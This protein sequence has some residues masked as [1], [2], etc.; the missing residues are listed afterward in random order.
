MRSESYVELGEKE[1]KLFECRPVVNRYD[2]LNEFFDAIGLCCED[3]ILTNRFLL[4]GDRT[5]ISGAQIL[6][7]ELYGAGEPTDEMLSGIVSDIKRPYKRVIGI[8]GGTVLDLSKLLCLELNG[9]DNVEKVGLTMSKGLPIVKACPV[10]LVPTT[11][12]TGS[13]VTNVAVLLIKSANTKLGLADTALYADEAALIPEMLRTLPYKPM[14]LSAIDA[15]IHA[16]ESYLS[17]K[18]NRI[19][20]ALSEEA[21][22]LLIKALASIGQPQL[23][24]MLTASNIAGIAFGNAG[25][26]MVHAMSYPIGGT[27]HLPHGEANY[28]VFLPVLR[29]YETLEGN[30]SFERLKD[31]FSEV[32]E[33]DRPLDALEALLER[34]YHRRGLKEIGADEDMLTAFSHDVFKRQQ[35]LLAN[36]MRP[37]TQE[38]ILKVYR[39]A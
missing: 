34:V 31:I 27:F 13:E 20:R 39:Q 6:Y 8:G 33:S 12:G 17:P 5:D 16:V 24:E 10:L 1:M 19:T 37:I 9:I 15:L 22:R 11:C 32:L 30:A 7:Q 18:A 36:A 35:R 2:S 28:E 23:E 29:Y 4:D 21:M 25:C 3:L 38:D 26:G 14:V